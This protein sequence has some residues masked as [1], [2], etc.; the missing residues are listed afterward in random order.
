[1]P[2]RA[3]SN[4][5]PLKYFPTKIFISET[6][7]TVV[8]TYSEGTAAIMLFNILGQSLSRKNTKKGTIIRPRK[9]DAAW[10]KISEKFKVLLINSTGF[11]KS[12]R[13]FRI[14]SSVTG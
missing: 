6:S 3:Q 8:S 10:L 13:I 4:V 1:M 11:I 12:L 14:T 5:S 9:N 7:D 2:T